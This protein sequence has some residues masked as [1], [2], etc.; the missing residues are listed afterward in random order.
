MADEKK[1]VEMIACEEWRVVHHKGSEKKVGNYRVHFLQSDSDIFKT[2]IFPTT[3]SKTV[4]DLLL[5]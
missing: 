2:E 1:N 5:N 3:L 4:K